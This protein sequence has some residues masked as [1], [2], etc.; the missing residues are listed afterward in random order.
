[1]SIT[2]Q[3]PPEGSE[4]LLPP[5]PLSALTASPYR[6]EMLTPGGTTRVYADTHTQL[7]AA[8]VGEYPE[9]GTLDAQLTARIRH[10]VSAQVHLQAA[11]NAEYPRFAALTPE[12]VRIA[13]S[14]RNTPPTLDE[15]SADLPLVLVD[16][17]YAPHGLLPRPVSAIADV[18]NPENL[19]W[20]RPETEW[21]YLES[22]HQCGYIAVHEHHTHTG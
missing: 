14:D 1:M 16:T 17:Y 2:V 15:W 12:E 18:S 9:S 10:A 7:L 11:L 5:A 13:T 6:F 19:W 3:N 4:I 22:L 21:G 20:L 8:L